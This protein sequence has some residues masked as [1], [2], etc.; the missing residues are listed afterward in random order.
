MRY[1]VLFI[2][3]LYKIV[4]EVQ[5]RKLKIKNNYNNDSTKHMTV[6]SSVLTL[7]NFYHH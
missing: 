1:V 6:Y 5:Q 3:L 2:Y 4:L 7:T